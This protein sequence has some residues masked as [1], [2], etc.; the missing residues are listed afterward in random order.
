MVLCALTTSSYAL[1]QNLMSIIENDSRLIWSCLFHVIIIVQSCWPAMPKLVKTS[2]AL[3]EKKLSNRPNANKYKQCERVCSVENTSFLNTCR[4]NQINLFVWAFV[5]SSG[6][7]NMVEWTESKQWNHLR[8]LIL[9]SCHWTEWTL[10]WDRKRRESI[11]FPYAV[12]Y[13]QQRQ[14]KA[15]AYCAKHRS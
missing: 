14:G 3:A 10:E 15:L 11:K 4:F 8:I 12:K 9:R 6:T 7:C 2:M 1:A 13:I 5:V